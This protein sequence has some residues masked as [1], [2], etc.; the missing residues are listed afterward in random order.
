MGEIRTVSPGEARGYS[1]PVCKKE[2]SSTA[3]NRKNSVSQ[4]TNQVSGTNSVS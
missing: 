3:K 4:V 2:F 1:F